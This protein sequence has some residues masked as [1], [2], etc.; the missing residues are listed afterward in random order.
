MLLCCVLFLICVM[1]DDDLWSGCMCLLFLF[2]LMIRRPPR[3]TR[4]DTLFPYT[5][6]FRSEYRLD[7]QAAAA[8]A[9]QAH[10]DPAKG[11]GGLEVDRAYLRKVQAR[12]GRADGDGAPQQSA[13]RAARAS[14]LRTEPQADAVGGPPAALCAQFGCQTGRAHVRTPVTNA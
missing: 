11:R 13:H 6:L 5:T 3:S 4:T 14:A 1:P 9:G 7:V 12:S 2:F 10:R 8:G